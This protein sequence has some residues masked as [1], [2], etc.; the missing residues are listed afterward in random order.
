MEFSSKEELF[1]FPTNCVLVCFPIAVLNTM[2]QSNLRKLGFILAS[3]YSPLPK[4]A[5]ERDQG[6]H[7]EDGTAHSGL[8]PS[9]S[10]VKQGN[11]SHMCLQANL[12]EAIL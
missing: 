5:R 8:G 4:E 12:V 11:A 7:L 3:D 9:T 10:I 1:P 6:R 2:T